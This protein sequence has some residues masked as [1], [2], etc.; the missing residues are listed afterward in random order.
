[1]LVLFLGM[2]NAFLFTGYLLDDA[3][4]SYALIGLSFTVPMRYRPTIVTVH[5]VCFLHRE[6]VSRRFHYYYRWLVPYLC[7]RAHTVVTVSEFSKGEIHRRLGVPTDK[8][9]VIGG[10]VAPEFVRMASDVPAHDHGAYVLGAASLQRR[11]NFETLIRGF[12]ALPRQDVSLVLAG[13]V[14]RK[15][16]GGGAGL[17][18]E[19]D[20]PR[21]VLAGYVSDA[22]LAALYRD[23]RVF[24]FPS[25]YEGFGIPPLEAMA[26]GCPVISSRAASLPEVCGDAAHYIDPQDVAGTTA[27]IERVLGDEGYREQLVVRGR[28]RVQQFDW[29]RSA[30]RYLDLVRRV[31]ENRAP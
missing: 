2:T 26:M 8:I 23:A 6:W 30:E 31:G 28:A 7:R 15:V 17:A 18:A 5:D 1:V 12:C 20:D 22:E 19:L 10:A 21:I 14:D 29:Q 4:V 3:R 24:V 9:E 11:K 16:Y 25:L 13:G 27:A